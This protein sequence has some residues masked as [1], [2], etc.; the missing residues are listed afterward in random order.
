MEECILLLS[1]DHEVVV[2][3]VRD[4]VEGF[5]VVLEKVPMLSEVTHQD[6]RH[7]CI[8]LGVTFAPLVIDVVPVA[9]EALTASLEVVTAVRVTT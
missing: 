7:I 6:K 1:K 8:K 4:L 9:V 3:V 5:E 2:E